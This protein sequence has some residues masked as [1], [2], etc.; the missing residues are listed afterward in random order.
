MV[1][2]GILS[3]I[4]GVFLLLPSMQVRAGWF[5][6]TLV[7]VVGALAWYV[8][9][10]PSPGGEP[11]P[12]PAAVPYR[13]LLIVGVALLGILM[14]PS[15]TWRDEQKKTMLEYLDS[16]IIAGVTAL[17]LI[18]Y[19]VR[20]FYIP[21]ESMVP[22]LKVND[23]ILVDEV[24]Y[25]FYK[26]ARGDIVVFHP[27]PRANSEGKD[28]IKR[29]VAV[30]GDTVQVKNDTTYINGRPVDEPF[31][32]RERLEFEPPSRDY[33]PMTVPP[34][35]VFCMGDNRDNSEDSRY[36]G[37]LPVKNIIGK[38]FLIFYPPRRIGLLH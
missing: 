36:W 35:Q 10:A 25:R 7:L 6:L 16:V 2:I 32:N 21:S 37:T 29:V 23:M 31:R 22:T 18:F 26:P 34:G 20:S 12:D 8:A 11:P 1:L 38:A 17:F 28:F 14:L 9:H 5:K 30:E 3:V 4:R 33:E 13:Y 24:V 19:V 27:P 15:G